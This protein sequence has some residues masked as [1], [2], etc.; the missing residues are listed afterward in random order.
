MLEQ[1][2]LASAAAADDDH[3][4]ALADFQVNAAEHLLAAQFLFHPNQT[5]QGLGMINWNRHD[6]IREYC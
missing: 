3:P 5:D 6:E 1:D 2:A 4:F